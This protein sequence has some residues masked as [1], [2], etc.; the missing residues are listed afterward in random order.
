MSQDERRMILQMVA[1][2]K[3]TASEGADLLLALDGY[4]PDATAGVESD[5]GAGGAPSGP[6]HSEPPTHGPGRPVPPLRPRPPV[7]PTPPRA[8]APPNLSG[9]GAF[10]EGIVEKV[11]S[12]VSDAVEPRFEF[13]QELTGEFTEGEIPIRISTGNGRI[14]IRAWDGPGYKAIITVKTGGKDEEEARQRARDAFVV[15]ADSSGFDLEA[16]RWDFSHMAVHVALWLPRSGR[17]RLE[18]RTGNGHVELEQLAFS[19]AR[20]S[21]GNGRIT[22]KDVAG[23]D[24]WIKTGNGAVEV[25]GDLA[26]LEAGT[27]NG[28]VEVSPSGSRPQALQ[29]STGNGSVRV[30]TA[31]LPVGF[32]CKVDLSTGMGGASAGV[33]GLVVEREVRAM[34]HKQLTGQTAN[35]GDTSV[36][37]MIVARTGLG[38]ISID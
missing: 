18:S 22:L 24:V 15:K 27:G 11:G 30:S 28:S 6:P 37:V 29:L 5:P 25:D 3:I 4:R 23:E 2:K 7:P 20:V 10:I 38:S 19:N 34:G 36:P 1:D 14:G 35:F 32:G 33:P 31:R 9:L 13:P 12:V 21:S 26:V 17:Y 16:R 8:P